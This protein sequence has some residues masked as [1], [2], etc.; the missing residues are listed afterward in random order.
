MTLSELVSATIL[1]ATGK[2]YTGSEGDTKWNKVLGIANDLIR[3]WE[4]EPGVDWTSLYQ[5]DYEVGTVSATDT[6]PLD[7][8]DVRKLS[9]ERGDSVRIHHTDGVQYTD[10]AIVPADKLKQYDTTSLVCAQIG[11]NLVF[12]KA[13]VSTDVQYGG[14][15][16]A[17]IY[18]Y[19]ETLVN[20]TD[21]VP[22]DNPNWLVYRCAGEYV[23]ND[24]VRQ[25]QYP[26]LISEA[27]QMM[28]K[29]R[30]NNEAQVNYVAMPFQAGGA[31]W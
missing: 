29:M 31:D 18:A 13:F 2:V 15:I 3:T 22:V 10:Y 7:V 16:K 17:P 19:A 28:E 9:D 5:K 21:D 11:A 26:N 6:Y 1:K 4:S 30:E 24:I 12:P 20:S 23:R 25:N 27:N 8:D 14:T